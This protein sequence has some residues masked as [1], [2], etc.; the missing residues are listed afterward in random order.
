[1]NTK[2]YTRK[3]NLS[4]SEKFNHNDF[5]AD[6]TNDFITLLEVGNSTKNFKGYENAVRAIRMKWDAISNKTV[7]GGLPDKLW[8]YFYATVI[9]KTK[10]EL[11]PEQMAQQKAA[12]EEKKQAWADRKRMR[13]Q[14]DNFFWSFLFMGMLKNKQKPLE[15][16][17]VLG[18][19]TDAT[20][21]DVKRK[22]RELSNTCHPD[23]GGNSDNFIKITEAKN[24]ILSILQ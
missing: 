16:Y 5:I 3:Y 9:A 19:S 18:L 21:E 15:S 20:A 10:E 2:E 14:E 7:N 23:K 22:Y 12:N 17:S 11:F 1:M 8:S 4:V 6:F 13:E 24:K